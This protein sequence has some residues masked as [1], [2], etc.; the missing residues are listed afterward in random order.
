[1]VSEVFGVIVQPLKFRLDRLAPELCYA[2]IR[3]CRFGGLKAIGYNKLRL[4]F[5]VFRG[6]RAEVEEEDGIW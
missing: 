4:D 6:R 2:K 1:M 5:V 3:I